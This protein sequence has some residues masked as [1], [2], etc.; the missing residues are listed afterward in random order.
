[1]SAEQKS[2][3]VPVDRVATFVR[4][5]T[6]DVRNGLNAVDLQAAFLAELINDEEASM[7][8][9]KMRGMISS[10]ARQLQ[11]ISSFFRVPNPNPI[12]YSAKIFCEDFRDR[13]KKNHPADFDHFIWSENLEEETIHADIELVMSALMEVFKNAAQFRERDSKI[14]VQGRC[15]NGSFVIELREKKTAKPEDTAE[16]GQPFHSTRRGG[17]GLG[18]FYARSVIE[19]H[20]GELKIDYLQEIGILRTRIVL[21]ESR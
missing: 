20:G 18:L 9:K 17:Y 13:L 15:E 14:E 8:L 6:H 1:M 19:A 4:Q 5:Y 21:P 12:S 10:V 7:E 11:G 3:Q 16:W 2:I